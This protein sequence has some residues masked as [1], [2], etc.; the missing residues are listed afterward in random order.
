MDEKMIDV[1]VFNSGHPL[2]TEIGG[3]KRQI[4][5]GKNTLPESFVKDLLKYFGNKVRLA[6]EVAKAQGKIETEPVKP[7]VAEAVKPVENKPVSPAAVEV[8]VEK[9]KT[10]GR[11]KKS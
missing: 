1:I 10:R 7:V 8:P 9:P 2:K 3:I 6:S 5:D 4:K 11:P